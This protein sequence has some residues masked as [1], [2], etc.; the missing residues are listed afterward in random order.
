MTLAQIIIIDAEFLDIVFFQP[1]NQAIATGK[2]TDRKFSTV[3]VKRIGVIFAPEQVAAE[4]DAGRHFVG[5][6]E[7]RHGQ[8]IFCDVGAGEYRLT[9]QV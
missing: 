3:T 8:F 4:T 6:V 9:S 7:A 2:F 5:E 1:F